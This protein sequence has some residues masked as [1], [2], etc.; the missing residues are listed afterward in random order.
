[1]SHTFKKKDTILMVSLDELEMNRKDKK[2]AELE[3][4]AA[5]R[6]TARANREK[7]LMTT[8]ETRDRKIKKL[9][10]ELSELKKSSVA[11]YAAY[12]SDLKKY[13][14][15]L[16]NS[17]AEIGAK[18]ATITELRSQIRESK[19]VKRERDALEIFFCMLKGDHEH[20]LF[21]FKG[22]LAQVGGNVQTFDEIMKPMID[23]WRHEY[24]IKLPKPPVE[25]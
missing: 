17:R 2:I 16:E 6:A 8:V 13:E 9:E 4:K 14:T 11:S 3:K 25:Q 10:D 19:V 20:Y 5:F 15:A 7:K 23:K 18:E 24:D 12:S 22:I 21:W 1:M